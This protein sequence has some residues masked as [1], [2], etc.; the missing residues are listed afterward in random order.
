MKKICILWVSVG[1]ALAGCTKFEN[2]DLAFTQTATPPQELS[3]KFDVAPNNSGLVRITPRAAGATYYDVYFGV[4]HTEPRRLRAEETASFTYPEGTYDVRVIA[5]NLMG[6]QVEVTEQLS[7]NFVAPE[8]LSV[9]I[10]VDPAN[11][12]KVN[13]SATADYASGFEVLFG[14]DDDADPVTVGAGQVASH[15]YA[16]VGVYTIRVKA[17]SGGAASTSFEGT[18]EISDPIHLP[19]TFE[20]PGAI[21]GFFNFDGGDASVLDNPHKGGIN[22]SNRV[23]RMIKHPGQPW[24]GSVLGLG[25]PIDFSTQKTFSMK[26]YSPRAGARVLL[27]VE[28]AA[29]PGIAFEVEAATTT[30]NQWEELRFDYSG[31]DASQAYNNLVLIFELGTMGDGSADFT[32]YFDDIQLID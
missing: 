19:L 15:T 29:N 5:Y 31:I 32:F 18:V 26:V 7:V 12:F 17:L 25:G 30:A 4:E 11:N 6:K 3:V 9:S 13:V 8:N 16:S 20:N 27:K 23:G 14:E 28:N 10:Q 22:A 21:F 1:L 24:G 2:G